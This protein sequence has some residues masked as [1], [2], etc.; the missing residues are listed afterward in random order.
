MEE[1]FTNQENLMSDDIAEI[2]AANIEYFKDAK[3]DLK[4]E[5]PTPTKTGQEQV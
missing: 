1:E 5:T 4:P 3:L 2:E